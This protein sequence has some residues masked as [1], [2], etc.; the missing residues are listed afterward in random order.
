MYDGYEDEVEFDIYDEN[1]PE[2]YLDGDGISPE[3]EGFMA[4]YNSSFPSLAE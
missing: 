3:E 1:A 4:G 2:E